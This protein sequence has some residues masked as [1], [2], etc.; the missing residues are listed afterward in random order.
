MCLFGKDRDYEAFEVIAERTLES[1]PMPICNY[2]LVP[3]HWHFV[4]WPKHNGEL[5]AFMQK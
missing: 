4:L 2:C 5:T 3:N 1:C